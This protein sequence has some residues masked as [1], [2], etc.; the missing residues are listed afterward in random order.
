MQQMVQVKYTEKKEVCFAQIKAFKIIGKCIVA[1]QCI[2]Y[3]SSFSLLIT[4]WPLIQHAPQH[5]QGL[6][7]QETL[8]CG[9]S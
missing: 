3:R 5:V 1:Q 9:H 4:K 7:I 6:Q 8:V 2:Q